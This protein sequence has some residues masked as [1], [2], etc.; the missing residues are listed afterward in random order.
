MATKLTLSTEYVTSVRALPISCTGLHKKWSFTTSE[1][2]VWIRCYVG[3]MGREDSCVDLF[4]G[5]MV[6]NVMA[7]LAKTTVT[8][9]TTQMFQNQPYKKRNC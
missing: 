6:K 4:N 1:G 5:Q 8:F 2:K 9:K 7:D 3:G